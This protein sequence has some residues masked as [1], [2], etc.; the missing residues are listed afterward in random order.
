LTTDHATEDGVATVSPSSGSGSYTY[1]WDNG[2]TTQTA[3]TLIYGLP[4]VTVTDSNG[5]ASTCEIDSTKELYCWINLYENV[6]VYVGGDGVTKVHGNGGYRPFAFLWDDGLAEQLNSSLTVG[7]HY[8]TIIDAKGATSECSV[9]ISQPNN[10]ICD[11]KDNDGDGAID[12]GFDTDYDGVADCYDIC[13]LGDD[14]VDTDVDQMPDARD[15]CDD[16][17]DDDGDGVKNCDAICDGGDDNLDADGDG[18]PDLCDKEVCD[19]VDNNGDGAIDEGLDCSTNPDAGCET[20]FAYYPENNACFLDDDTLNSNR[21]GW[22]NYFAQEGNYTMDLYSGACQCDLSKGVKSGNVDVSYVNGTV[23]ISIDVL[24]G[25]VMNEVKIY[26]GDQKYPVKNGNPTVAPGKYLFVDES[27]N[28]ATEYEYGPIEVSSDSIYIIVHAVTGVSNN[29]ISKY[30]RSTKVVTFP[31]LFENELN[32]ELESAYTSKLTIKMYDMTGRMVVDKKVS[33][34][35][36]GTNRI[37]LNVGNLAA[38]MYMV[39]LKTD[40]EEFLRKVISKNR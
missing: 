17:G 26:I 5:C 16:D 15:E 7:S 18:I 20:A 1:L 40:K 21:W 25:F 11:G 39:I 32:F 3:T 10:E 2:E 6:S 4:T 30:S 29:V 38:D 28:N 13:S 9:I 22:T 12:E 19:G 27:L 8:L 37:K 34:L 23:S 14:T 33:N 24:P 36:I 35:N 31:T